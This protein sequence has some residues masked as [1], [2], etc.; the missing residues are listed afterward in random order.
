MAKQALL[1]SGPPGVG[2]TT[3][4]RNAINTATG[5]AGGFYTQEIRY[6]GVRQGFE[7]VTLDGSTAVMA[8]VN[9]RASQRVGR[10]G[11]DVDN[12]DRVGVQAMRQAIEKCD[13]VVVDEIGK[14][15][16]FS[17]AFREAIFETLDSGKKLLGTIMLQ[18]H[19]WADKVKQDPRV[20]LLIVSRPKHDQILQE[21]LAWLQR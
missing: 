20:D 2:K 5:N 16:L 3:I 19:P 14:M 10:Y 9:L 7:I 13:I 1:L 6:R 18:S 11:V 15:E 8:H 21:L 17:T 12:L 4:I